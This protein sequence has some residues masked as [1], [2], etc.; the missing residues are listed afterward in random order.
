MSKIYQYFIFV[1]IFISFTKNI[2]S[3]T[4]FCSL[5]YSNEIIELGDSGEAFL[6]IFVT[7]YPDQTIDFDNTVIIGI[8]LETPDPTFSA[9]VHKHSSK[10]DEEVYKIDFISETLGKNRF[11]ITL[12]DYENQQSYPLEEVV[13]FEIGNK[14]IIIEEIVPSRKSTKLLKTLSDSYGENDTITVEFSLVDTKGKDIIGNST[15]IKKLKVKNNGEYSKDATITYSED[16]KTFY[17]TMKPEYLPLLQKINVEFNGD[18]DTFDLFSDDLETTI[19]LSPSYLNTDV[20]CYNC[21]NISYNG[22]PSIDFNLYNYKKIPV[23]T[24]DYSK[25]FDLEIEG[26]LDNDWYESKHYKAKK[27]EKDGNLYTIK[28]KKGDGFVYSGTYKIKVYEDGILIKEF[29]FLIKDLIPSPGKTHILKPVSK[30]YGENDTISM[31]FYLVDSKGNLILGSNT[32]I[33]RLKVINNGEYVEDANITYSK[34]GKTFY[35]T[36]K[37]QYLPLLQKINIEY[38]GDND[39]FNLFSDDLETTIKISPF[40]LNTKV[41]CYN[42]K[43]ISINETPLIDIKLYNFKKIPVNSKDYSDSYKITIEGP[44]DSEYYE[45]YTYSVKKKNKNENIYRIKYKNNNGFIHSGLYLIKVYEN[46]FLIKKFEYIIHPGPYDLSK[47]KLKFK[48][49]NFK[50]EKALVDT[51]FGLVLKGYDSFGNRVSLP[52]KDKIEVYLVNEKGKEI[53]YSKSFTENND[54]ELE[55][56]ITSETL[57]YAKLKMYL[58]GKEI[59]RLNKKKICLNLFLIV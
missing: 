48:D 59:L 8:D 56:D 32:L 47:F 15:F 55:I 45:S 20:N 28:F 39:K 9:K 43:N 37:P 17:L 7:K 29:T 14:E 54:G 24:N 50:P 49:K 31:E 30:S 53:K 25:S 23:D 58:D 11:T 40:Y 10:D 38:D 13:E 33:Q 52:L 46:D 35:L 42:C 22:T 51:E 57:G 27:K 4:D 2:N 19:D 36:M 12:Y 21:E 44:L 16:G 5:S 1:L 41:K 6:T 34:D 3:K 26:P 18:K